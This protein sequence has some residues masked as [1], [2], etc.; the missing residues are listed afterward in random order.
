MTSVKFYNAELCLSSAVLNSAKQNFV[1]STPILT[2]VPVVS[3][4]AGSAISVIAVAIEKGLFWSSQRGRTVVEKCAPAGPRVV[5]V[6][7][8]NGSPLCAIKICSLF[9]D[10]DTI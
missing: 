10:V 7:Q 5:M 4:C 6:A 2:S 8:S 9:K 1:S 3:H